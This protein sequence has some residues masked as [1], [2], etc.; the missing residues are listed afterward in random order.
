M[1]AACRGVTGGAADLVWVE[2]Q[3]LLG[4]DVTPW[5]EIP[6]WRTAAGAWNV[7]SARAEAAGLSCRPHRDTVAD[8]WACMQQEEPMAHERAG[9]IGI[10]PAKEQRLL[11]AWFQ[12]AGTSR[13]HAGS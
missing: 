7:S 1:L 11:D 13:E 4:Q 3:W 10:D 8:T 5:T 12:R 9:E 6:L 2:D